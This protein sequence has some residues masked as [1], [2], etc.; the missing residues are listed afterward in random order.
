LPV[1][2]ESPSPSGE[3]IVSFTDINPPLRNDGTPWSAVQI[4]E[5]AELQGPWSVIDFQ[6]LSP[7]DTD[8]SQPAARSFTTHQASIPGGFYTLTFVDAGGASSHPIEQVQDVPSEI[9][10]SVSDLGSFMRARTVPA[11]TG[12]TE[13]GTF[14][15]TTRPTD[16]EALVMIAQATGYVLMD[17]GAEIPDR[18]IEQARF[19]VIL[20][21]ASLVELTFYRNE[22]TRDQSSYEQYVAMYKAGVAALKLAIADSDPASPQASFFS[23]PIASASQGRFQALIGAIDPITGQ[24]DPSKLPVDL[25]Y[26][27]GPGGIPAE[28]LEAFPWLGFDAPFALGDSELTDLESDD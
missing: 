5:A 12:G 20:Y 27:R 15:S 21:A 19:M 4:S 6:D 18:M 17:V 28:L 23:V 10:P 8:P 2:I 25:Y 3:L 1:V 7:L 14:T 9:A 26:P 22:V 24:F 13:L 11:G 16:G